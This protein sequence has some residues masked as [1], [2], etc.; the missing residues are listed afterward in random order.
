MSK[1]EKLR[2]QIEEGPKHVRFEDLD[3]LLQACE[4]EVRQSGH[5]SSHYFYSKGRVK[6][7]IPRRRPHLLPIYVR[8]ALEAIDLA[9]QQE[10]EAA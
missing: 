6:L 9:E 2:K 5:G 3:R 10:E 7:S 1:I 8:L 4:F